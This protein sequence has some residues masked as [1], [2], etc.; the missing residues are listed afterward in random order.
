MYK[1]NDTVLYNTHGVCKI[2][3]IS[4]K[5]F[6]GNHTACYAL[7]PVYRDKSMVFIPVNSNNALSKM[8][9]ILSADQIYSL[10]KTIPDEN[11][12]WIQDKDQRKEYYEKVLLGE[13][14]EELII[15]IKTLHIYHQSL[16]NQGKKMH[17]VD[18]YFMKE[19][20]KKLH[21][22]FAYVLNI[23]PD[24]VIPFITEQINIDEKDKI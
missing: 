2:V 22:E 1:I 17:T 9:R 4:E 10:I 21:E 3:G 8:H 12:V 20:E 23:K 6:G 7:K 16:L 15:L 11:A 18:R 19:A 24:E 14:R 5:D 13:D